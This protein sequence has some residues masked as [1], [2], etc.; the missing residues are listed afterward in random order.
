MTIDRKFFEDVAKEKGMELSSMAD[1]VIKG[2]IK[3]GGN[4]PCRINPKVECPCEEGMIEVVEQGRCTCN[5][6]IKKE[7]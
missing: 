4:C 7:K 5:L 6:F 1:A 2:I 3:K